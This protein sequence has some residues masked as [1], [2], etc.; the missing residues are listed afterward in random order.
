MNP[1]KSEP[2][3]STYLHT[4]GRKLGLP[5]AGNFELTAR[6]NFNCPMCYV[7]MTQEQVDAA[8]REL[9][10]REW[11]GI[12]RAA[13]DRGMVFALLTGG[14]PLIRRDF[15]EI[16]EGMKDLG[17]LIS[18]NTNGSLLQGRVLDRFLEAPPARFNI[19]LYGGSND[20]YSRMCGQPFYDRVRA[21][22][23]A[24]RQAGVEVSLNLSITPENQ[25]DLERIYA[26]AVDL[27]VNIRAASYMYPPIRINGGDYGHGHRLPPEEAAAQSV[28]WD[29][30]RFTPEE[31]AQR[32]RAMEALTVPR[33]GCPLEDETG[34]RCRAGSTSFWM[35]WDGK[36]RPCGMMPG[37]TAY[38]LEVGF[39]AAWDAIR[40]ETA[41]IR[42]PSQCASCPKKEV[43]S[44]CAA[45]CVTETGAFDRVP[46]YVCRMTDAVVRRTLEEGG[47]R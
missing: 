10:A 15:F 40:A 37:P 43:C 13:R 22:I 41:K 2:Y 36:M 3:L 35:T 27:N 12:A 33:E 4:K 24:L 29:K 18:V 7:H 44:V 38:P 39:D 1:K 5:I 32:A 20:T 19:S 42:T 28:R 21:N 9:T 47:L 25:G 16:Y 31:F 26:D 34:V 6:C 46:E 8:G 11:L 14:E 23:R 30:L 17:L 45:V